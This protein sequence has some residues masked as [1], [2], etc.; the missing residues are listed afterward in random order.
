MIDRINHKA[1]LMHLQYWQHTS[2]IQV[3]TH[4]TTDVNAEQRVKRAS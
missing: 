4:V 2:G 3:A 1:A